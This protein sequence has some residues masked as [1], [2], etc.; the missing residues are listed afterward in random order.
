MFFLISDT[1]TSARPLG[2]GGGGGGG[3]I[4]LCGQTDVN[5]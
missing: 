3:A 4:H 1:L 2:G 5:A